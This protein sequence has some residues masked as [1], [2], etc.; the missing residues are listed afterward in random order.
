MATGS[1]ITNDGRKIML[2][3]TWKAVPDYTAPTKFR[4]GTGTTTP[5]LSDTSIETPIG[6][7]TAF[8]SGFPTLDE[9]NHETT[10]RGFI[11]SVD[12]NGN[13]ISE[14]G[15]KNTDGTPLLHQRAVFT[16]ITKNANVQ[17]AFI[18]KNRIT[19]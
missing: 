3:R 17:I 7:D 12:L 18:W 8:V 2:N 19:V 4:T 14:A 1:L 6:S 5:T 10:I 9:T 16:G 13:T 15:V 11:S